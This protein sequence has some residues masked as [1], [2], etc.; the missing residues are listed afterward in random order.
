MKTGVFLTDDQCDLL[1][2]ALATALLCN[3]DESG[4][5]INQLND[6]IEVLGLHDKVADQ[7]AELVRRA[8]KDNR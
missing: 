4:D 1:A 3:R 5:F 2:E 7:L 8:E 6:L